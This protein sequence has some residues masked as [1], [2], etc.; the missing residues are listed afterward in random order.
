M[1]EMIGET[2][3]VPDVDTSEFETMPSSLRVQ[4][5][6]VAVGAKIRLFM[7]CRGWSPSS[8]CHAFNSKKGTHYTYQKI[9]SAIS[10]RSGYRSIAHDLVD[11]MKQNE[12]PLLEG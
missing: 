11:F 2:I 9:N 8:L 4:L 6:Q 5:G 3:W 12:G 10:Y 7:T 1:M